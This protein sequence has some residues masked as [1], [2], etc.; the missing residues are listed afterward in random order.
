MTDGV[1]SGISVVVLSIKLWY[2]VPAVIMGSAALI[3]CFV[4]A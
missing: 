1:W 3:C 2:E 4:K